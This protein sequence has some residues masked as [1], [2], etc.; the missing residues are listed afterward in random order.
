M[1]DTK[2]E[3]VIFFMVTAM[4]FWG[5]NVLPLIQFFFKLCYKMVLVKVMMV[6]W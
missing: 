5:G 4:N 3:A 6:I 1:K 2:E